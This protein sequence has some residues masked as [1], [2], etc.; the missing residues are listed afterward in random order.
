MVCVGLP[1]G[2]L[3]FQESQICQSGTSVLF[4]CC[5]LF[6]KRWGR[7][8][9]KQLYHTDNSNLI[10]GEYE[11][12]KHCRSEISMHI[13]SLQIHCPPI[14]REIF[15][16]VTFTTPQPVCLPKWC[17]NSIHY[18]FEHNAT[19]IRWPEVSL[20]NNLKRP[21]KCQRRQ[22]WAAGAWTETW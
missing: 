9:W 13:Q 10:F 19:L 3:C 6:S 21:L 15:L 5:C 20:P 11:Y 7:G 14:I 4:V 18:W 12:F 17:M 8:Y 22:T 2:G 1:E 16:E